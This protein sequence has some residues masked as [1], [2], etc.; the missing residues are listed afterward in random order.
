[1]EDATRESWDYKQRQL[2]RNDFLPGGIEYRAQETGDSFMDS[3][4]V[5]NLR[6]SARRYIGM[7]C[8]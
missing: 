4:C 1:M 5:S 7:D 6:D 8:S 3:T 2:E